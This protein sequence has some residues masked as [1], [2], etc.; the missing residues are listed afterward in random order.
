MAQTP[1]DILIV[2][3]APGRTL[4]L[5]R[6]EG[7]LSEVWQSLS[8]PTFV[9]GLALWF[10]AG[11]LTLG[12]LVA[13]PFVA[14]AGQLAGPLLE[15]KLGSRR[16]F[17]VPAFA[18]GRAL[19][20][21]PALLCLSGMRGAMALH[22]V[23]LSLLVMALFSSAGV[24]GWTSWMADVVVPA[25]RGRFFGARTA[26]VTLATMVLVPAGGIGLDAMRA[27]GREGLGHGLLAAAAA[28]AGCLGGLLLLRLPDAVPAVLAP[29]TSESLTR[30]LWR[31]R[32]F[33]RV[34]ALFSLWN[35]S[36]GMPAAFWTVYMLHYLQMSFFLVT[37]H[38]SLILGVRVLCTGLWSRLID[39][40]GS[41][42]VLVASAF[43][44]ALIPLL[45]F[46][47]GP[48]RIWPIWIEACISG[49]FW[50]GF[51]QSAFLQ[52]IIVLGPEERS[53]GL[54]LFNVVTGA[55]MF[56]ASVLGGAVVHVTGTHAIQSYLT[57]FG[58][59]TALRL[60]T[61]LL[62]LRYTEPGVAPHRFLFHFYGA[63]MLGRDRPR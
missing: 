33:R 45:W 2:G 57:L 25:Q 51:G 19:W 47:P 62:A 8:G 60:C 44:A 21:I 49:F 28:L 14:Q 43:G 63:A 23:A 16:R 1:A 22:W 55:A 11:P 46:L 34:I 36:I 56:L 10:G 53:R 3:Q 26:A 27:Q 24:N 52:P 35:I 37:I 12:V 29:A 58:V 38:A 9:T 13:L 39:Q 32:G 48:G 50:T 59:V 30:R 20:L 54:A 15:R 6:A 5:V 41:Q 17:V 40:V 31:R 61:A 4:G 18:L 42:R 7:F